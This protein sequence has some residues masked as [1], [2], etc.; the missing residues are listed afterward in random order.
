MDRIGGIEYPLLGHR[1]GALSLFWQGGNAAAV[2][3]EQDLD[4]SITAVF[5]VK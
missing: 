4:K 2:A 1:A 3:Y 5:T